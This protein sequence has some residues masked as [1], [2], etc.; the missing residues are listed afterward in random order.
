MAGGSPAQIFQAVAFG[1]PRCPER[2][3]RKLR[4]MSAKSNQKDL[5]VLKELLEAGRLSR[6]LIAATL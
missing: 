2:A 3:G 6:L 5:A 4:S 1:L